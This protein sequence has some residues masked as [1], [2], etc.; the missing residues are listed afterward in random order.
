MTQEKKVILVLGM[1]RSGTSMLAGLMA[2]LGV[3]MGK[4]LYAAQKGVNEKGFWEHEDIVDTHDELLLALN[5]QWDD[6]LPLAEN[7]TEKSCIKPFFERLQGFVKRDFSKASV[8]ALKDPR[9]CRL[10]PLWEPILKS[11]NISPLFVCV[12][13]NPFEVVASLQKRD[14]FTQ[15]KAL[16]LWLTHTLLAEK[17]SRKY[18]RIFVNFDELLAQPADVLEK[19][20]T[21]LDFSFPLALDQAQSKIDNFI[22]PSL[23]HHDKKIQSHES[24]DGL[25]PL[26]WQLFLCLQ[27]A[28]YQGQLDIELIN[29]VENEF[30]AYQ[31][32]WPAE[33]LEQINTLNKERGD[34]RRK[35]FQI[36]R[37][38]SWRLV[39]PVWLLEKFFKKAKG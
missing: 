25:A 20:E 26:A 18:P 39:K 34:Y 32:K 28:A 13:R 17:H 38:Y 12:N 35:F 3:V 27:A 30:E 24:E 1:H 6:L 31:N 9:M 21:G 37:S 16:C 29:R 14:G 22:S 8:W 10:M 5:S 2:Q 4:R 15:Q 33:L 11:Q 19:I 7:W 36:Y 23:R